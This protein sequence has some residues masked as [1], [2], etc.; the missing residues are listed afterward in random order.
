MNNQL[1]QKPQQLRLNKFLA[2]RLGVS[3]READ[4]LILAGKVSVNGNKAELGGKIDKNDKLFVGK[5]T[6]EAAWYGESDDVTK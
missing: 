2:E 3:R 6:G 5:L 1:N 4:E